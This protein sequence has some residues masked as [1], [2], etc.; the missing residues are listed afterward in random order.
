MQCDTVN[1]TNYFILEIAQRLRVFD[2]NFP[3]LDVSV[4]RCKNSYFVDA[5]KETSH[6]H[7]E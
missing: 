2:T 4:V 5:L 3:K 6:H 1:V 7:V